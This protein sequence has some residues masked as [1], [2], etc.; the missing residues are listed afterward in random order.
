MQIHLMFSNQKQ[1]GGKGRKQVL[2]P[3]WLTMFLLVIMNTNLEDQ[4]I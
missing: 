3:A 2:Y 1:S 4:D